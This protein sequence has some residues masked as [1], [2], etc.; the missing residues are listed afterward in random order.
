MSRV[1]VLFVCFCEFSLSSA[2]CLKQPGLEDAHFRQAIGQTGS[3]AAKP[4]SDAAAEI[5]RRS[6]GEIF[7]VLCF[8]FFV[9]LFYM[10]LLFNKQ[11]SWHLCL[12]RC[13]LLIFYPAVRIAV[14]YPLF[15]PRAR[16]NT[17]SKSLRFRYLALEISSV[18]LAWFAPCLPLRFLCY[19][20]L[21]FLFL[22]LKQFGLEDAHFREAI[23]QTGPQT[24]K[25]ISDASAQVDGRSLGEIFL[26]SGFVFFVIFC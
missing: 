11:F 17:N 18:K 14:A 24:P 20:L 16:A 5:D 13:L 26:V 9:I 12:I 8:V 22:F 2:F 15:S 25:P 1:F 3:Q 19:L 21:D 6:L 4:V 7:L 23:G 10:L